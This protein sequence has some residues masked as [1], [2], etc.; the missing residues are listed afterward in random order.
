MFCGMHIKEKMALRAEVLGSGLLR[1]HMLS[2]SWSYAARRPRVWDSCRRRYPNCNSLLRQIM[3]VLYV[4]WSVLPT[5]EMRSVNIIEY[6]IIIWIELNFSRIFWIDFNAI[7]LLTRKYR[8]YSGWNS[9]SKIG[10]FWKSWN[11]KT[12]K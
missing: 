11:T 7:I 3:K 6:S 2:L 4:K 1:A 10:T 12:W 5:K 8:I 9:N